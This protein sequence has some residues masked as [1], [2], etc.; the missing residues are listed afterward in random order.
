MTES[1]SIDYGLIISIILLTLGMISIFI[2]FNIMDGVTLGRNVIHIG[3]YNELG[4]FINGITSPFLSMAAFILL[5]LTYSSQKTELRLNRKILEKQYE[6]LSKQQFES[7]FFNLLNLHNQIV[8]AITTESISRRS[9]SN[10]KT[11][12]ERRIIAGRE[13]FILFYQQLRSIYNGMSRNIERSKKPILKNESE[14]IDI[15]Y[16]EF[17]MNR[18]S[19]LGHYYR[20]LFQIIKFVDDSHISN[21]QDYINLIGAQ[22]SSSE[23]LILCFHSL[24]RFGEEF[25]VLIEKYSFLKS[26]SN[27]NE[28]LR[29]E[30]RNLFDQKAFGIE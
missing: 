16:Y 5:F 10:E 13:C 22:L 26:I 19:E 3:K 27:D 2:P 20:N 8:N 4:D 28:L 1:K 9:G 11:V 30:C 24:S 6:Q 21:K 18:Q 29:Y 23:L 7:T 17:F 25:K 15:I 14:K 12:E